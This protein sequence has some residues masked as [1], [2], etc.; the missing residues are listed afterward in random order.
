MITYPFDLLQSRK[1][2]A[3]E[4]KTS[5]N[6]KFKDSEFDAA[7]E[8]YT[9]A[10][11]ICPRKFPKERSIMYSNRAACRLHLVSNNIVMA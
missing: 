4:L 2:R 11:E 6:S 3:Q 10:L 1:D 8:Q 5:G 7:I 9:E